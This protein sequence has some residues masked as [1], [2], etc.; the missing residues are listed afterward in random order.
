MS[1]PMQWETDDPLKTAEI[2]ALTLLLC[3][4]S[5]PTSRLLI[6]QSNATK[7]FRPEPRVES[8]YD[9]PYLVSKVSHAFFLPKFRRHLKK[10]RGLKKSYTH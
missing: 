10:A 2:L 5:N 8:S 1:S 6:S 4:R 3:D 7:S 9:L